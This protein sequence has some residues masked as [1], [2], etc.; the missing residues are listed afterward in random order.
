MTRFR[1]TT[2]LALVAV[3]LFVTAPA[4]IAL[5]QEASTTSTAAAL[6][7]GVSGPSG[8]VGSGDYVVTLPGA[9][10]VTFTVD[11]TGAIVALVV[12]PDAGVTAG[13]PVVTD[14][15]V[16]ITFTGPDGAV[17]VLE[18]EVETEDGVIDVEIEIDDESEDSADEVDDE[19]SADE[20][21]DESDDSVDNEDS[22]DEVDDES[23]DSVDDE[24]SADEV[25]DES[26]DEVDDDAEDSS[27]ESGSDSGSES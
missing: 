11:E 22:A 8:S 24:D 26:D 4:G 3:G 25:D 16:T 5:A 6:P 7:D 1:M 18:I 19:D 27:S 2:Y 20:V 15:G 17:R 14:E 12:T 23:D 10:S 9:G 21:D 13:D